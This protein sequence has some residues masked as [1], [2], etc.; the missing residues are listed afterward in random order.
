MHIDSGSSDN[1]P[2]WGHG[3]YN[4]VFILLAVFQFI[5]FLY[6]ELYGSV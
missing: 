2:G 1:T 3:H 5:F 4:C 6:F